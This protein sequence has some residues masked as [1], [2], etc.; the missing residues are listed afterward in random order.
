MSHINTRGGIRLGT[1]A[2]G[3]HLVTPKEGIFCIVNC[4]DVRV[5]TA[6]I[7]HKCRDLRWR[8]KNKRRKSKPGSER[9]RKS[10]GGMWTISCRQRVRQGRRTDNGAQPLNADAAPRLLV[11]DLA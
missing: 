1:H 4:A 5:Q 6:L 9:G 3:K 11:V 7:K 8:R 2:E 10:E